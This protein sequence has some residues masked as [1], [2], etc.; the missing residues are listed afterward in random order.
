MHV[1]AATLSDTPRIAEI[2]VRTW[3]AAYRGIVPDAYLDALSVA[4]RE[5]A[6]RKSLEAGGQCTLVAEDEGQIVGWLSCGPS[7]DVDAS[8]RTG[9]VYGLYVDPARW[10]CGA[11]H[12][13]WERAGEH[14]RGLG[15][16][17]VTLWVLQEN[18]AAQRFDESAGFHRD[19]RRSS[20][21]NAAA[22][23]SSGSATC[24]RCRHDRVKNPV[25]PHS[26]GLNELD[27]AVVCRFDVR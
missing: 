9:E 12:W 16:Q 19:G 24:R 27:S 14:L 17:R 25:E 22:R 6:W 26:R 4:D 1:R 10:R 11:G 8:P 20:A 3:Q 5:A 18:A 21:A 13:L 2:H 15:C 23:N 7:R